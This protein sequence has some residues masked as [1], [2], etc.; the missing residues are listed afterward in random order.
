MIFV[1]P[2]FDIS[3]QIKINQSMKKFMY[4]YKQDGQFDPSSMPEGAAD[5]EMKKWMDW[6]QMCGENL[7]DMG[8]PTGITKTVTNSGVEDTAMPTSGYSIVQAEDMEGAVAM[9]KDHPHLGMPNAS[10]EI[11]HLM[12]M[13]N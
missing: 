8:S 10:I 1:E 9:A 2:D 5:A 6:A 4:L 7:T 13:D 12:E 11:Y 3:T